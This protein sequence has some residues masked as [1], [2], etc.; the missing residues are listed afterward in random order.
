MAELVFCYNCNSTRE[1]K[2]IK[3]SEI[4]IR[5]KCKKCGTI[6]SKNISRKNPHVLPISTTSQKPI[7]KKDHN[8]KTPI[9]LIYNKHPINNREIKSQEPIKMK[10][11]VSYS[12]RDAG[13]FANQVDIY[14]SSFKYDI[15]TDIN[16]IRGG[17]V[18]SDTIETNISNCDI[19]VIIV[20]YGALQSEHVER[21]VLQAQKENKKILPCLFRRINLNEIKWGLE[22]IQGVEFSDKYE[23]ARDLYSKIYVETKGRESII[24]Y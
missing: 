19:F 21:E 16:D 17:D 14:L 20:T 23:L 2:D 12:R 24:N 3:K 1:L 10:I 22:R 11:F 4:S 13:D 8:T 15:F 7:I 9:G 5:G 6:I 18:W